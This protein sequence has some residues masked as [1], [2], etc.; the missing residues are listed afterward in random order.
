MSTY[1][2]PCRIFVTSVEA[3]FPQR[4][5]VRISDHIHAA[6]LPGTPGAACQVDEDR[7]ELVL[8]HWVDGQW[9]ANV[10]NLVSEWVVQGNIEQQ[11]IHSKDHDWPNDHAERNLVV[12][13]ER[14]VASDRIDDRRNTVA[15]RPVATLSQQS[16]EPDAGP[17]R[18][19]PVVRRAESTPARRSESAPVY[20]ESTPVYAE[21]GPARGS[22]SGPARQ[23]ESGPA[24]GSES[25]PARQTES[26]PAR[27]SESGPARGTESAPA[28]GSESAP[29]RGT[30]SAPAR[31][32]ESAPARP[33]G[34]TP[35]RPFGRRAVPGGARN[36]AE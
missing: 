34:T 7:W 1:H 18:A 4:V 25:G 5:V 9:W 26:G 33:F 2:G 12:T 22:E 14:N 19:A 23:T 30:E 35:A 16:T 3:L 15:P 13:L 24:R 10:R 6:V 29:A 21:S 32:T 8:Q 20:A 17:L 31:G 11:V 28:R 27:G 36:P